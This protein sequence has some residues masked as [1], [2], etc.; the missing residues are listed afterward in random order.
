MVRGRKDSQAE[1]SSFK[2]NFYLYHHHYG[3]STKTMTKTY[4][5][6]KRFF[7]RLDARYRLII[8][9]AV[10]AIAFFCFRGNVKT[11]ALILVC[12]IGCAL[13]FL[14]CCMS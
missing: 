14:V 3:L 6:D 7:Y 2:T 12:W 13:N 11:P 1:S 9:L 10:S 4:R 8:A 5:A